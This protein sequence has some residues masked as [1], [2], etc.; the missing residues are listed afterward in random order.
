MRKIEILC[1][2][3]YVARVYDTDTEYHDYRLDSID[4]II[5]FINEIGD[6][7][8]HTGYDIHIIL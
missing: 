7:E 8:Y 1:K 4:D 5:K 3:Y 2:G 6:F